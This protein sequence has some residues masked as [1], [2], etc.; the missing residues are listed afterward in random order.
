M[1]VLRRFCEK[2]PFPTDCHPI[3]YRDPDIQLAFDRATVQ[4]MYHSALD[5]AVLTS[6][7][8]ALPDIESRILNAHAYERIL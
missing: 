8:M 6:C 5:P 1:H 2:H 4:R 7:A 3:L